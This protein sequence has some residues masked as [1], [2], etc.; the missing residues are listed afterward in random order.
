[1]E[2][3]SL[4][5]HTD[6][7]AAWAASRQHGVPLLLFVTSDHCTFCT[8]MKDGTLNHPGVTSVVNGAFVPLVLHAKSESR[9]LQEL[10]VVYY[11]TTFVIS[12][13]AVVL[14]RIDGYIS[15]TDL[16]RRLSALKAPAGVANTAQG[17]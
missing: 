5:W 15:P 11:P 13:Q 8:R 7:D 16:A 2:P 6:L 3:E 4:T 17:R 12:P 9:L 14:A 10:R 1:M